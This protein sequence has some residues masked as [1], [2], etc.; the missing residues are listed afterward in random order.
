[1]TKSVLFIG[2]GDIAIRCAKILKQQTVTMLGVRR[3]VKQLPAWLPSQ[4]A[5]VLNPSDLEFITTSR[6]DT[7]IYSLSAASFDEKSYTEAYLT[8]LKNIISSMNESCLRKLIFVSST[9]VY[10]QNDDSWVDETSETRPKRFNGQ[11]MLEAEKLV[12]QTNIGTCVRFSGIYGPGR[13][14]MIDRVRHGPCASED[15]NRY[16]NRIHAEDCAG[17]LAHL[18]FQPSVPEVLLGTDSQPAYLVD[19]ENFIASELGIQKSFDSNADHMTRR[20][21]GSKRCNNQR[22]LDTGYALK[23]PDYRAGYKKMIEDGL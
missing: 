20:G 10:H 6:A 12:R 15:S 4:S 13:L 16:T 5:S 3:N 1:M 8:G 14:S 18:V 23:Y 9:S 2:C 21:A 17:M 7:I 22:L 19:V 11:I